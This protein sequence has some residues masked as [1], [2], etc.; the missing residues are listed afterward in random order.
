MGPTLTL[1]LRPKRSNLRSPTLILQ[2][3]SRKSNLKFPTLTLEPRSRRSNPRFL[4]LIL[5]QKC[6]K[7]SENLAENPAKK[8]DK[9]G[10]PNTSRLLSI[11]NNG[12]LLKFVYSEKARKILR[13]SELYSTRAVIS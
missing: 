1:E 10:N 7:S 9:R 3:R 12:P 5:A 2:P 4:M 11:L 6:K 8:E 13:K